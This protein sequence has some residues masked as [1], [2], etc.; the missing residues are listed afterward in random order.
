MTSDK[1]KKFQDE[2]ESATD[3]LHGRLD[4][5]VLQP[6]SPATPLPSLLEQCQIML[7]DVKIRATPPIRLL[8]HL[9]CTGGTLISRCLACMP[10]INLLS[11]VDPLSRQ[12]EHLL[13]GP[14]DLILLAKKATRRPEDDLL[15]DI[16]LAG[17]DVI[18]QNTRRQGQD[19]V[20]RDHAHSQFTFGPDIP[21]RP[22]LDQIVGRTTPTLS[23]V[24]V[25]HP[26]DTFISLDKND[27]RHFSPF[28]LEEYAQRTL[29]FLDH[30]KGH[31]IFRYEDFVLD[32][33]SQLQQMCDHLQLRYIPDFRMTFSAITISGGSG[34]GGWRIEPLPRKPIP[35]QI[36]AQ[37][38]NNSSYDTLCAR[39]GY[40]TMP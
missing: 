22:F 6:D 5:Q 37:L 27:W 2:I 18:Y 23:L 31:P 17:L 3:L 26:L 33:E 24:T 21:K 13:F 40:D 9:A 38:H 1:L 34:R 25:R 19:L 32:P 10:N 12:M 28:T 15:I 36:A 7:D 16:F 4:L 35:D 29:A 8:H 20:L 14:T 39:L 11:E 30:Y